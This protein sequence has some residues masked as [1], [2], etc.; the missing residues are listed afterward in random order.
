MWPAANR[1]DVLP[2]SDTMAPSGSR[3]PTIWH[4]ASAVRRA[5][6][7]L[8]PD[9][10]LQGG[11]VGGGA[12]GVGQRRQ[13]GGGVAVGTGEHV[14]RAA[15]GHEVAGLVGVG[16]ERHRRL[17]VDED[18]VAQAVELHG[19]ELGEVGE[20][21]DRH[22]AG[23]ALEAGGERLGEQL[24]AGG[25]GD[26]AGV[27][28]GVGPARA[29]ADEQRRRLVAL[30]DRGQLGDERRRRRRP[31]RSARRPAP[32]RRRRTSSRRP[33]GSAWPPARAGRSRPRPRR[34][35]RRRRALVLSEERIQLDTLRATVSMSV[36]SWASY[37]LW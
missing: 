32:G 9:R 24:G 31:A 19:G 22:A 36:S 30:E 37:C 14:D 20:A 7:E 11:G 25:V 29:P 6:R 8:G 23:A 18:Q 12:D 26:A 4:T 33:A 15:V 35:R 21:V 16:E 34:R 10:G 27:D 5:G 17:G 3:A 1:P 2:S 13:R 28:E